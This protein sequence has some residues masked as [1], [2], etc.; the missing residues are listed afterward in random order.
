MMA[1]LRSDGTLEY[2]CFV[3]E[4]FR[5]YELVQRNPEENINWEIKKFNVSFGDHPQP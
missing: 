1:N 3:D 5:F 4:L 2:K